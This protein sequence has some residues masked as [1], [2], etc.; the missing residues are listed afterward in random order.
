MI[1]RK[2]R[3]T[4]LIGFVGLVALMYISISAILLALL[5]GLLLVPPVLVLI[6][7]IIEGVPMIIKELQSILASK[8]NFF[9]ISISKE[10][11]TLEPQ[12]R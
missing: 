12:F 8:K 5:L 9:V 2:M 1:S 3:L 4:L 11:I 7:I 10:S 6:S